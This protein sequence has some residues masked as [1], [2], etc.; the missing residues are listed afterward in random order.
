METWFQVIVTATSAVLASL[1]ASTGFWTYVIRKNDRESASTRLMMGLA[2][3]ELMTL[4][5]NYIQRGSITRDEYEDYRKYFYDPY[6]ELGGN[7]VAERIMAAV[8]SLPITSHTYADVA[9]IR[10]REGEH[11]NNARVVSRPEEASAGRQRL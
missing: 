3:I 5:T 6:K 10:N 9:E 11:I 1:L 2:Y 7:G 4:G 8:E